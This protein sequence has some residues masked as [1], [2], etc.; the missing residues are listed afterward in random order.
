MIGLITTEFIPSRGYYKVVPKRNRENIFPI[1]E[2]C[3]RP[4]SILH[5]DDYTV[6]TNIQ[7][8]LP[9]NVSQHR[10]VNHSLNFVDPVTGVH[11]QNIESMWAKLKLPVK[12]KMGISRD[13][14]QSYLDDRMWREW[15]GEQHI[16]HNFITSL[17]LQYTNVPV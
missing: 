16:F 15:K 6:Y 14:L 1:I 4:G 3:L 2:K 12:M 11:T 13:D 10:I 7:Q 9:N 8:L 5:T 17:S